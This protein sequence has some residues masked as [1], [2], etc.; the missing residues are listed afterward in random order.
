MSLVPNPGVIRE[1]VDTARRNL[2]DFSNILPQLNSGQRKLFLIAL[3]LFQQE[4]W[5]DQKLLYEWKMLGG[6]TELIH[7]TKIINGDEIMPGDSKVSSLYEKH[8]T[9]PALEKALIDTIQG[10]EEHNADSFAVTYLLLK[11]IEEEEIAIIKRLNG[12]IAKGENPNAQPQLANWRM[13]IDA[14]VAEYKEKIEAPENIDVLHLLHKRASQL[15]AF[16]V[17]LGVLF[18]SKPKKKE[19]ISP[20]EWAG[21]QESL[22]RLVMGHKA[23]LNGIRREI[24]QVETYL[25]ETARDEKSI[26]PEPKIALG[27]PLQKEKLD[28]SEL[29]KYM[30][31]LYEAL[32]SDNIGFQLKAQ[33]FLYSSKGR[34]LIAQAFKAL[35]EGKDLSLK[36]SEAN[37]LKMGSAFDERLKG[38]IPTLKE[39]IQLIFYQ[40]FNRSVVAILQSLK[41]REILQRSP[42]TK[43]KYEEIGKNRLERMSFQTK[44]RP[45]LES[46]TIQT[47]RDHAQILRKYLTIFQ[48][49]IRAMSF[50]EI[51]VE[52]QALQK[53]IGKDGNLVSSRFGNE[54]K[55][56]ILQYLASLIPENEPEEGLEKFRDHV[57]IS[58]ADR[59][60]FYAGVEKSADRFK[61]QLEG[62]ILNADEVVP[63]LQADQR[64]QDLE[65]AI[66]ERAAEQVETEKELTLLRKCEKDIKADPATIPDSFNELLEFQKNRIDR[67]ERRKVELSRSVARDAIDEVLGPL[68]E[69]VEILEGREPSTIGPFNMFDILIQSRVNQQKIASQSQEEAWK[70]YKEE[71]KNL[72]KITKSLAEKLKG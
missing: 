51:R 27:S 20:A 54:Q 39:R 57:L 7:I 36:V 6:E 30:G 55:E 60:A 24:K 2:S 58:I 65:D 12:F 56:L 71:Q 9:P 33:R 46:Y 45:T 61:I 5:A 35:D 16:S 49:R 67:L 25:S 1:F 41:I 38:K 3:R 31:S 43:A 13:E 26:L 42:I 8:L 70:F 62:Q 11:D 32:H 52:V 40:I 50:Q 69:T 37:D 19:D 14:K 66:L 48:N 29:R 22:R 63:W 68:K 44:I 72:L 64:L 21:Y 53:A 17:E 47:T 34:A 10:A 23:T 18:P 4:N 59:M 28:A 15:E